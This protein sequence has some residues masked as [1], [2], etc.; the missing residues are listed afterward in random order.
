MAN[1]TEV[2]LPTLLALVPIAAVAYIASSADRQVVGRY[3]AV[4]T[5]RDGLTDFD[6]AAGGTWL[7]SRN[8]MASD[9]WTTEGGIQ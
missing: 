9:K 1:E 5:E 6:T 8:A 4:G 2:E 3:Q 7:D